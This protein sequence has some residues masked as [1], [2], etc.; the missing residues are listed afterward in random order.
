MSDHE[1]DIL[2]TRVI[3]GRATAS[4]WAGLEAAATRDAGV[5]RDLALAQRDDRALRGAVSAATQGHQAIDLSGEELHNA[6]VQRS[7]QTLTQRARVVA[8]WGGWAVAA[9]IALALLGQH[10]SSTPSTGSLQTTPVPASLAS[11]A[12]ALNAY[13][14]Q[15]R[16]EGK[17]QG[18]APD[19]ELL[20]VEPRPGGDGYDVTFAR[21]IIEKQHVKNFYQPGEYQTGFDEFGRV[22]RLPVEVRPQIVRTA[23]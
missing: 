22:T 12:D 15:G 10:Q 8:T 21:R 3:D 7:A 4:D 2:M 11:A 19:K 16:A 1:I 14:T 5:W 20:S 6:S 17:V 23:Y 18:E 9:G 13:L